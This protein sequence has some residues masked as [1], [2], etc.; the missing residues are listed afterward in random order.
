MLPKNEYESSI[1]IKISR[2]QYETLLEQYPHKITTYVVYFDNYR[3][4]NFKKEK[5]ERIHTI[6]ELLYFKNKF[7]PCK[8]T[9]ASEQP[10]DVETNLHE[11]TSIVCRSILHK[12]TA[13][14]ENVR[15][16]IEKQ[17]FELLVEY[18]FCVEI[19]FANV[20]AFNAKIRSQEL[21]QQMGELCS[22]YMCKFFDKL[23][24]ECDQFDAVKFGK[25]TSRKFDDIQNFNAHAEPYILKAKY[26]GVKGKFCNNLYCIDTFQPIILISSGDTLLNTG[27]IK[28]LPKQFD[29]FEN[30]IF[31]FELM[32]SGNVIVTDII[33]IYIKETLFS[34]SPNTVLRV[35]QEQNIDG[36]DIQLGNYPC[37]L[38]TQKA[39]TLGFTAA[40]IIDK[41][42]GFIITS[43]NREY[44]FKMPTCD[45]RLKAGKLYLDNSSV[46]IS[47]DTFSHYV[48]DIIYEIVKRPQGFII[49]RK[50]SDRIYT[51]SLEEYQTF[52][53]NSKFFNNLV[54]FHKTNAIN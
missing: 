19:E 50:R 24:I 26:D 54:R 25:I 14:D 29:S 13:N 7:I 11:T 1:K 28:A 32:E 51:S 39:L 43:Q 21:G 4:S 33:G 17:D 49:L 15:I 52:L 16:A 36:S 48:D 44:K 12:T 22:D 18:N 34:P 46:P 37:K 20:D 9:I 47:Y 35:F 6:C 30:V 27:T 38:Y 5:K 40:D 8:H 45:V 10:I 23:H 42:D 31:Q 41:C 53:K 3:I 2:N